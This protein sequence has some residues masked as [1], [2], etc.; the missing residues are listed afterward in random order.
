MFF[1]GYVRTKDKK[2]I[3]KFKDRTDFKT[4][5]EVQSF[6][7][8]AGVLAADAILIDIDDAEQAETMMDIV[9]ALQLNCMVIQTTRGKH[10]YF[11]NSQIANCST[12]ANLACG[13]IADIKSGFKSCYSVLKFNGEDR[14][15][16]WDKD[17]DADYQEVPKWLYPVKASTAFIGMDAGDGRNQALFNY[18]LTL[19]A[20]DFTQEETKETIRIINQYLL[21]EPLSDSELEVVLR[22]DAFKQPIFFKGNAFLHDKFAIFLKNHHHIIRI[23]NQL[24]LYKDGIYVPGQQEIESAMITHIPQLNKSK[25]SEV[26]AYLDVLIRDNTPLAPANLIAFR[27]GIYDLFKGSLQP[28]DPDHILTNRIPWD[29]NP[30]AYAELTDRTMNKIACQ[31]ASIRTLLEE[32]IGSCFYRSN[33]LAGGK[34]F[35]LTG[36]GANGKSTFLEMMKVLL[37]DRN[38]SVLDLKKLNDRFSTVMLFGQLANIGDDISDEFITDAAEFKKIVTGNSIDAEQKGQPKFQFKPYVKLMFSANNIPRMGKGR[39]TGAILRRLVIVPFQARFSKDD[40]D[41]DNNIIEGLTTQESMEYLI[42]IGVEALKGV[43][44]NRDYTESQKVQE[45]LEEF[46]ESNNPVIGFFKENED[47]EIENQPTNEIFIRYEM[48]CNENSISSLSAGE[49]SKQVKKYYG[50]TIVDKKIGG[51]KRRIFIKEG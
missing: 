19:Q 15:V 36:E 8:Y 45:Q 24:H 30:N 7:E 44:L 39:D 16:E 41:Y 47:W 34:A 32:M 35:I 12:H 26:L 6:P 5:E 40:A 20:N 13:L 17:P 4:L 33:T 37:G 3:E 22:D 50:F 29:Y 28:F 43:I 46:E 2:C 49:F 25:R 18:I 9:E 11:K 48:F 31:D 51:K 42:N 23:N 21:K 10:F 14:F 27:N 1:K 38:Y